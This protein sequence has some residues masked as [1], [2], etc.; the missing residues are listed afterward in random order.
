MGEGGGYAV[1]GQNVKP[2]VLEAQRFSFKYP[3]LSMALADLV[4]HNK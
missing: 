3:E 1:K 2:A 4:Q